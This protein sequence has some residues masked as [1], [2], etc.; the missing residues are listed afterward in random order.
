MD[1]R[2]LGRHRMAAVRAFEAP[3]QVVVPYRVAAHALETPAVLVAPDH[4]WR[5]AHEHLVDL[6]L[7]VAFHV[8]L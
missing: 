6:D 2:A 5:P 7:A 3:F 1:L 4:P 8:D